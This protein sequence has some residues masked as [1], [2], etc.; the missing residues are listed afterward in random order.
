MTG[1]MA[2]MVGGS[3]R[4]TAA[5]LWRQRYMG[6]ADGNTNWFSSRTAFDSQASTNTLSLDLGKVDSQGA[7]WIGYWFAPTTDNYQF[8]YSADVYC[9]LWIGDIARSGFSEGN[10]VLAPDQR[11]G[12]I[13]LQG[14]VYYPMRVQW[15]FE[16][17]GGTFFFIDT[18]DSAFFQFAYSSSTVPLT[19]NLTGRI[20]YNPGTQGF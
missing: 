16:Q 13:N 10:A 9:Y 1:I 12:S 5:G 18:R 19:Q 20:F 14:G 15:S 2:A 4:P 7:Q 8:E 6:Y 3:S 17:T 11:S